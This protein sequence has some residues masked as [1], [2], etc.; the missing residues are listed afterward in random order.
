[1][2]LVPDTP[3]T[4]IV[5]DFVFI[6]SCSYSRITV[7]AVSVLKG[8]RASV[9]AVILPGLRSIKRRAEAEGLVAIFRDSGFEWRDSGCSMCVGSNGDTAQAGKCCASTSP[10]NFEGR[11]GP[12]PALMS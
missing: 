3:I 6:G 4:D 12:G 2:A 11:Q 8:R 10:R 1:M 5:I 9:P 7:S